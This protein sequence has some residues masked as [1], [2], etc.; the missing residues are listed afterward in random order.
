MSIVSYKQCLSNLFGQMLKLVG[1]LIKFY[2]WMLFIAI[3]WQAPGYGI[4]MYKAAL[5]ALNKELFE[6][7]MLMVQIH[8]KILAIT[9][10]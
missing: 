6:A 7:A 2:P 5:G 3:V 4:V 1:L 10:Q 8:G 9:L